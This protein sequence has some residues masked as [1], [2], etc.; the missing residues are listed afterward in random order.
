MVTR[1]T[2]P[3][4][5]V[6][7]PT[8]IWTS[9]ARRINVGVGRDRAGK[10]E[11]AGGREGEGRREGERPGRV[12]TA[13]K[14]VRCKE[15]GCVCVCGGGVM[16]PGRLRENIHPTT[17]RGTRKPCVDRKKLGTGMCKNRLNSHGDRGSSSKGANTRI[18]SSEGGRK[19]TCRGRGSTPN[20]RSRVAKTCLNSA[21]SRSSLLTKA[22]AGIPCF[23]A[24]R[25]TVSG[26]WQAREGGAVCVVEKE[27]EKGKQRERER[28][29]ADQ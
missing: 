22:I 8:G 20:R 11:R 17:S 21:P 12:G 29:C 25:H 28:S 19:P 2:M 27:K 18:H 5:S 15:V 13:K 4:K 7:E 3:T 6:P 23:W 24:V 9:A 16:K 10:G 1:S 26:V 14:G